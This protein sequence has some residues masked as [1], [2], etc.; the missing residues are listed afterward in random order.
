MSTNIGMSESRQSRYALERAGSSYSERLL[1]FEHD[2]PVGADWAVYKAAEPGRSF[3]CLNCGQTL[4][5]TPP[6]ESAPD[7]LVAASADG[8]GGDAKE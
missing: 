8:D 3:F 1:R 4:N 6:A 7:D 5:P 2:C